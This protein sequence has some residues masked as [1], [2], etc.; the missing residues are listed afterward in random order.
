MSLLNLPNL[1]T[2]YLYNYQLVGLLPNNVS[3][4]NLID[5]SLGS[6]F[7]NGTLP[8]WLFNLPSLVTLILVDNQFIGEIDEF[9]SNSLEYLHLGY[10]KL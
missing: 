8:S 10:N 3:G 1:S 7:L 5:L 4:F 6:N 2:L 9:K